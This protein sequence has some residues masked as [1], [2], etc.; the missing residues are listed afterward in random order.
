M[1]F[2][3]ALFTALAL[4]AACA[5]TQR[6]LLAGHH[7]E[8]ALRG[9]ARGD[10]DGGEV[11][12]A[13][14]RDLEP[15]LHMQAV[16]ASELRAHL[17]GNLGVDGLVLVRVIHDAN[18][19]PIDRLEVSLSLLHRSTL[20]PPIEPDRDTLAALTGETLPTATVTVTPSTT[21]YKPVGFLELLGRVTVNVVTV[22]L[23]HPVIPIVPSETVGGSVITQPPSESAYQQQI[24][25]AEALR[26]WLQPAS[27]NGGLGQLCR[28]YSL[29]PRPRLGGEAPLE[30]AV[31]ISVGGRGD[32]A[33]LYRLAIPPGALEGG[34]MAMFGDRERTLEDLYRHHGRARIVIHPL[35]IL[36]SDPRGGFTYASRVQFQQRV[37]GTRQRPGLR[38]HPGLRFRVYPQR[39]LTHDGMEGSAQVAEL[40]QL[41]LSLGVSDQQITIEAQD[42]SG[43]PEGGLQVQYE[44]PLEPAGPGA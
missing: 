39:L 26:Q 40:R 25:V 24:P 7:Y 18:Q 9:A 20:L 2:R 33:I 21:R 32:T 23:I 13:I 4:V 29:W 44:L 14:E 27:C 17:G 6:R 22:G 5:P 12:A 19:I 11:L 36:E 3:A 34:L 31:S 15:G 43:G 42:L 1:M 41:L 37:L 30:L 16:P 10:I 38:A 28:S 35:S 8:E